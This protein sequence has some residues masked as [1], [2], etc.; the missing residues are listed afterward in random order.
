MRIYEE[1]QVFSFCLIVFQWPENVK[2]RR[3][4]DDENCNNQQPDPPVVRGYDGKVVRN[5]LKECLGFI[6][7]TVN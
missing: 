2:A 1:K 7:I 5:C 6:D 3:E 4:T